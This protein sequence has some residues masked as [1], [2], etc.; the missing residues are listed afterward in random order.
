MF[1]TLPCISSADQVE[2]IPEAEQQVQ[3][4]DGGAAENSAELSSSV[5]KRLLGF[6]GLDNGRPAT[7][8][9]QE[10]M[11]KTP[12]IEPS[13][14]Q[15]PV[16]TP[17]K[18]ATE[19][20]PVE[21][22]EQDRLASEKAAEEKIAAEKAEQDRQVA[23]KAEQDRMAA[24]KAAEEKMAAEKAE[25]ER[26]IA[27]KIEK[28]RIA[29]EKVAA[30]KVAAVKT[31]QDRLAAEKTE[32]KRIADDKDSGE[33]LATEKSGQS[34]LVEPETAE[35]NPGILTSTS[36][37]KNILF[38]IGLL[39]DRPKIPPME[40]KNTSTRLGPDYIIG[41]GDLLGI[42]VWRDDS[43]TRSVVVLPDGKIQFPL[44]GEISAGGK[45]VAQLKQEFVEKLS[46]YVVDA[47]ISVEVKQSNSLFI[48]IMG[49]VNV[50][51]RQMLVADTT[52][53]QALAMAG[54][55]NP[56]AEKDDIKVFRQDGDRTLVYSFRYSLVVDGKYLEDNLWLKRGDV[57][58]VP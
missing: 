5:W 53:L 45:S 14:T 27:E 1:L 18:D 37:W 26:W 36:T 12:A 29:A 58:V 3:A 46:S 25:Q 38:R 47:D 8:T 22:V 21:N 40:A 48:Y 7:S 13:V 51:G 2:D 54:G 20:L 31:E 6:I 19:K 24:E 55:L 4:V 52:V 41:P 57:I 39:D 23:E 44:I 42:S 56:F 28:D 15:E 9:E 32:Q 11:V 43:L 50:P 49:K 17:D 30:E 10:P 35:R 33:K 34:R 16:V